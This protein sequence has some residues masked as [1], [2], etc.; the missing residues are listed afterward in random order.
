MNK[1]TPIDQEYFFDDEIIVSQTDLKGVIV[2]ANKAF[3]S[4]S[5]YPLDELVGQSHSI[6]RHPDMPELVFSKMW[7]TI[8]GAQAWNGLVK[9]LRKDGQYYWVDT[10]IL[11]SQDKDGNITGY[12]AVR[13]IASRKDIDENKETYNKMLQSEA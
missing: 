9:N 12:M 11:P 7:V 5:G 6:V 8:Q 13:K 4:I 3:S 10:E 2:Y 1:V